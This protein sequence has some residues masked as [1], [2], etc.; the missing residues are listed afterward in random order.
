[1]ASRSEKIVMTLNI[2]K[3]AGY[4][5]EIRAALLG[6]TTL[7]D[8]NISTIFEQI[9]SYPQD[10]PI[11]LG[12]INGVLNDRGINVVCKDI[13]H[14]NK[15]VKKIGGGRSEIDLL[16]HQNEM[17]KHKYLKYKTG[18]KLKCDELRKVSTQSK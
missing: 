8:S 6:A 3:T 2:H 1:M 4:R 13:G 10:V 9:D 5:R 12:E 14:W 7:T 15:G 17:L 11:I 18:Y 16:K